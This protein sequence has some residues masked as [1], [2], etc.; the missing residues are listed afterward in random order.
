MRATL[1]LPPTRAR[2]L[3]WTGWVIDSTTPHCWNW[4]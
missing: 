2:W 3:S 4:L 1:V